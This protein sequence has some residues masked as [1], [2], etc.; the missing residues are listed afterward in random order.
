MK[1]VFI[2]GAT[3]FT[4]IHACEYYLKRGYEVFA[5]VRNELH[6][7]KE[8]RSVLCDLL[9]AEWMKALFDRIK[10]DLILHLAAQNHTGQSWA[11]PISTMTT[12]VLGTLNL[13]E[14]A[15]SSAPHAKILIVGSVIEFDPCHANEPHHP[16]GLSKYI[17]SL[18][19]TSWSSLYELNVLVVKTSNLIGPGYSNGICSLLAKRCIE[20]S[21]GG[22]EGF[23]FQ[24][25]LDHRDFLDVRD[26]V[27]AY[28][29]I[30]QKGNSKETY[31]V[32]SGQNHRFLHVAKELKRLADSDLP[33]TTD[34]FQRSP[35][36]V[37]NIDSIEKLGWRKRIPIDQSLKDII[38]YYQT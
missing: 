20:Y 30:L 23:H 27:K 4:G 26:A 37:F 11:D 10:P 33:L 3:G 17:Q 15:R 9:D 7:V 13:L 31:V 19:S 6:P 5:A 36:I 28:D 32:A 14:G 2:S 34:R 25:I 12:N 35:D 24:N 8:V 16:Y 18:L 21:K 1:K 38:E 29:C 22:L